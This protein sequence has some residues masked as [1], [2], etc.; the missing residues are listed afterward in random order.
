MPDWASLAFSRAVVLHSKTWAPPP[1]ETASSDDGTVDQ[2]DYGQSPRTPPTARSTARQPFSR[3]SQRNTA[4]PQK[5]RTTEARLSDRKWS[6]P[7][8][9]FRIRAPRRL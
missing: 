4:N 7:T 2:N 9:D 5:A 3:R 8:D 1:G 6:L